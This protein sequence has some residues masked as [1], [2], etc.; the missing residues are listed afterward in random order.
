M[1]K[2]KKGDEDTAQNDV[3]EIQQLTMDELTAQENFPRP[4]EEA[5]AAITEQRVDASA[6]ADPESQ[7]K[8][9]PAIHSVGKD[10]KPTVTKTGKFRKKNQ[11]F[12][13]PD[14][15][16][17]KPVAPAPAV[18]SEHAAQVTSGLIEQLSVTLISDD[19]VYSELERASNIKA[20]EQCYDYY[21]GVNIPPPAALA[22]NHIGIIVAR[23]HK[24]KPQMK[25]ALF[26]TW[27]KN[28]FKRKPK[29]GAHASSGN[30][31]KRENNVGAEESAQPAKS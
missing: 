8:F 11:K 13:R 16:E 7:E 4:D 24:E 26:V 19:F 22:L 18:T 25:F 20:W 5:I 12:I 1:A 15:V 17:E 6:A 31:G 21:G 28:K 2:I 14:A 23:A 30:D 9:D 29:N 3:P 27:I 10:G